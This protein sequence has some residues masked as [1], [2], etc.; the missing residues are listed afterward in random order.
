[1]RFIRILLAILAAL[2]LLA[3]VVLWTLPASLAWRYAAPRLPALQLEGVSGT[4][5]GGHAAAASVVGQPLGQ[6]DWQLGVAPL[7]HGEI[8]TQV[9]LQGPLWQAT[10][11]VSR[12][13]DG[14]IDLN[15]VH[16][17]APAAPLQQA[18]G[19]G[20]VEPSGKIIAD[21]DHARI[22]HAW[23]EALVAKAQ[24]RDAGVSGSVQAKFGTIDARFTLDAARRV[25]GDIIDQGDG[26]LKVKGGFLAQPTGYS[27]VLH[28]TARHADDWQTQEALQQLGQRQSDGSVLLQVEGHLMGVP[29]Q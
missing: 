23:F 15:H 26:A 18:L 5:W 28:L 14:A 16:V 6:L 4:I 21:I 25:H 3:V 8:K 29:G 9:R 24:W 19:L 11:L 2:L 27:L 12:P 1:M 7:F 10:G 20:S 13:W 17:E 22:R